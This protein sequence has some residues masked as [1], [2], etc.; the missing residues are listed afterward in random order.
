MKI[1]P[2]FTVHSI[3][4]SIVFMIELQDTL[5]E[6]GARYGAFEANAS[7]AQELKEVVRDYS[8]W[9]ELDPDQREAIDQIFAKISRIIVGDRYYIDN[10]HDIA[11]FA[12][13]VENRIIRNN[14]VTPEKTPMPPRCRMEV[15]DG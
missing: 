1:E 12:V 14:L 5:V 4:L 10:W 13:L 15:N 2:L 7:V 9:N 6:R 11:G 8:G 3:I